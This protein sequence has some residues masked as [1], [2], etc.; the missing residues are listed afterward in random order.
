MSEVGEVANQSIVQSVKSNISSPNI[1]LMQLACCN[2]LCQHI[3]LVIGAEQMGIAERMQ[4]DSSRVKKVFVKIDDK[5]SR[6]LIFVKRLKGDN[7]GHLAGKEVH[8]TL[9]TLLLISMLKA[10]K[11]EK[12][13]Q[14][15]ITKTAFLF[16]QKKAWH[17]GWCQCS[18][19]NCP[20]KP[21]QFFMF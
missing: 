9:V 10:I 16:V 11:S 19:R 1:F 14:T 2:L 4:L 6:D 15:E 8:E 20:K 13:L 12:A 21:P 5:V 7:F 17:L 3:L 18:K